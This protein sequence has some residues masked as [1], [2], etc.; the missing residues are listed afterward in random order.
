MGSKGKEATQKLLA[1]IV[2]ISMLGVMN[3]PPFV[4]V[5]FAAVAYFIWRAVQHSEQEDT[6]R[7]FKFYVKANDLLRDEDKRWYGYEIEKEIE[8]GEKVFHSMTD[9]PPLVC[10]ALGALYQRA[11]HHEAAIEHLAEVVENPD[12]DERQRFAPSPE[13]RR[14]VR[15]LRKLERE[16]AE[17]PQTMVA[18]RSLERARRNRAA[19]LL[20]Q[21]REKLNAAAPQTSTHLKA[22]P[23][24]PALFADVLKDNVI[25]HASN[26]AVRDQNTPP[27]PS[28]TEVLRDVYEEKK[29]A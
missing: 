4:I 6:T 1:L 19:D 15:L 18:V 14:Y 7:I 20:A 2:I 25:T 24:Q 9:P 11:G 8:R 3:I 5:F 10:F 16:P 27:P 21:S 23:P 17:A 28:I 26:T 22:A 29:T 13:L 12:F